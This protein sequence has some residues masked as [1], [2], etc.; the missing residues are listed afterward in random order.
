MDA[1]NE[2]LIALG[3]NARETWFHDSSIAEGFRPPQ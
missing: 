3:G 1:W 2:I